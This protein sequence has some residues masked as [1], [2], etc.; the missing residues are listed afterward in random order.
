VQQKKEAKEEGGSV[1]VVS[2]RIPVA[3]GH[4]DEFAERFRNRAQLVEGHP[5]FIRLEICRPVPVALHG[6]EMG[7]SDYHVV[8]TYW[9][10]KEDFLAWVQSEDFRTA[11]SQRSPEGMFAGDSV[12]ELHEIIQ[13]AEPR[14]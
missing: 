12:F 8:L 2:N 13:I 6:R 1:F 7:G 3:K 4:E 14:G 10:K 5:G 11:H 9:T